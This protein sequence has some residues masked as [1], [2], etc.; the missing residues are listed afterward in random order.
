M[1]YAFD[2]HGIQP[3]QRTGQDQ[4]TNS[5]VV[6]HAEERLAVDRQVV[7]IDQVIHWPGSYRFLMGLEEDQS[8]RM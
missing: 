2:H 4:A 5:R 8:D 6:R 7:H 3:C 1:R